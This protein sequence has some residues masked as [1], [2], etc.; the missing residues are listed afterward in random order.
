MI[1]ILRITAVQTTFVKTV[2]VRIHQPEHLCLDSFNARNAI[3]D[4]VVDVATI[5]IDLMVEYPY[6]CCY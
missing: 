3:I 4:R 2:S 6:L 5:V 1:R